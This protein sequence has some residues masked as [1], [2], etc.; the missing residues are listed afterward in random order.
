MLWHTECAAPQILDKGERLTE[1]IVTGD[2]RVVLYDYGEGGSVFVFGRDGSLQ[3]IS[4]P[5]LDSLEGIA[6]GKEGRV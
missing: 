2:G 4:T 5:Q 3:G 1:G 6:E